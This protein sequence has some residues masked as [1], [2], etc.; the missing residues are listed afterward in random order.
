MKEKAGKLSAALK[1]RVKGRREDG[2]VSR[3]E[4]A[5]E[6]GLPESFVGSVAKLEGG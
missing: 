6:T 5:N 1:K 4:L 2:L 3:T